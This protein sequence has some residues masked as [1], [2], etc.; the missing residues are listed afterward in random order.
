M[1]APFEPSPRRVRAVIGGVTVV[2]TAR[3][4]LLLEGGPRTVYYFRREDMRG[5]TLEPSGRREASA[6]KGEA[7]WWTLAVAGRRIENACF[8]YDAPPDNLA[9][10]KG[11]VAFAP[12]IV[13]HWLEEDEEVWGH[14]NDP[15]HR[16]DVR[17]SE[18]RVRVR[19]AGEIVADTRRAMFLFETGHAA[20][21]Y[22]P[23]AD[24]RMDLLVPTQR[25]T[26]CPYKG[27]ASYWTLR[28]G[29]REIADVAWGY[30]DPLPECPRIK[31][32]LCFYPDKVDS[33]EI[34]P[35]TAAA[36]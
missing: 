31:G 3:A 9:A 2:D 26:V 18:R 13:E 19:V 32:L 27:R 15:Y 5:G 8:S 36:P 34:E 12:N 33:I 24:V 20:R 14:P 7:T 25:S 10:M 21:Y 22:L 17:P 1:P 6:N 29:G 16:V 11:L 23:Q 28:L 4:S 35:P 30:L